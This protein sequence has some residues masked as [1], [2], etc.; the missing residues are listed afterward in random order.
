ML[1]SLWRQLVWK[2]MAQAAARGGRPV[3]RVE[4]LEDRL[5]PAAIYAIPSAS[6]AEASVTVF[7]SATRS[8]KFVL[9]PF[10]GFTGGVNV[11]IG[12]VTGDGTPDVIVAPKAGGGGLVSV[13]NGTDGSLLKSFSVGDDSSR[14]GASVAA[15]DFDA[16]GLAEV[17]VGAVR[18]GQPL[19]QVYR[20]S[21]L[22]VLHGYTPFSGAGGVSVAVGDVTGD[23]TPD[24][25]AAAGPGAGPQVVVFDGKTDA[26]VRSFFAFEPTFTGGVGVAA[27]D[28]DGDGR[29]DILVSAGPTG[30]PRV[31]V[32]SGLTGA[33]L[34]N[35]FA[36]SDQL[37]GGVE[38]TLADT[39][40]NGRLD[41]V[42]T[43]G[44]TPK[45]FDARTMAQ[46]AAPPGGGLVTGGPADTT[47]PTVTLTTT[48]TDPS[49]TSPLKFTATFS[50][51]VNGFS[52]AGVTVVNGTVSNVVRVDAKTYT[53]DVTP[54]ADG[55]VTVTV[56]AG[57]ARDAAGNAS[58]ASAAVSRTFDASGPAVTANALTTN[59]TTPAL[60]GTVDS[61]ATSVTVVVNGQTITATITGTSWSAAVPTALAAGTYTVQVTARD[62]AGNT[63]ATSA[64]LVIDTTAPTATVSTTAPEPTNTS[65]IPFTVTFDEDVT[66]FTAAGLNVTNGVVSNF[67][68]VNARTYTFS[69]APQAQGAVTVTV[70][71]GAAADTAGNTNATST[72]VTRTFDSTGPV[73]TANPLTTNDTTPTLTGTVDNAAATVTV[74][75]GGQTITATVTGTT[76]T[77]TLP[78]ALAAGT[79]DIQVTATD[80]QGNSGTTTATG[81]LVI[82]TTAPTAAVATTATSPTNDTSIT[83]TVT[84]SEDVTGFDQADL[85]VTGGTVASVT[86]VDGKTYT[87]VITP[88]GDGTVSVTVNADAAT[89]TAGNTSTASNTASVVFDG[90]APTPT[91]TADPADPTAANPIL[92]TVTFDED[93]TGFT[94]AGVAVTNGSVI[95]FVATD[96]RTYTFGVVPN[97]PGTVTVSTTAGAATDTAGNASGAATP[98]TRT[99]NGTVVT[100]AITS[101]VTGPTQATTIPVTVEF[102]SDVTGFDES[103]L[104]LTNGTVSNFVAVDGNTYT[105][106]LTPTADGAVTV[107]IAAGAATA[108]GSPTAAATFTIT[109][110]QTAPTA[111]V[112]TGLTSPTNTTPIPFTVTFSEDVTGFDQTG[113]TITGGTLLSFTPVDGKTYTVVVTP[114]GDGLVSVTVNAGVAVDAAG[115]TN[116]AS[117][118]GEITFDGTVPTAAVSTTAT[119]P[120]AANP[121]TFTVTFGE[122]V[123]GFAAG[124]LTVVNGTV[125]AITPVDGKT[126]TVTITPTGSGLVSVTV[127]AGAAADAAGNDNT[128]SNTASVTYDGTAPTATATALTTS[129]TTP[130]LTGTVDDPAATVTVVVGGQTI[131]ATVT[132]TTWTATL[133]NALPP[134][135]YDVQ[136]TATDALGND[137]TTTVTG[138]LVIDTA[139]PTVTISAPSVSTVAGGPVTFT[140]T[141]AD[142]TA[143]TV[144]LAVADVTL[145]PTGNATGT[146]AVTG[147][148]LV[149]TVTI[150]GITGT[151][152]L[153]ISL[154]AGTATDAAGNTAAAAG[155]SAAVTVDNTAPPAPTVTGLAAGS[156]TGTSTAD[157]I[158]SD[159]TPTITGIAEA[160]STVEVFANSGSGPVSL[161]TATANAGGVWSLTPSTP[162]TDATYTVTAVA[163]DAAGND[164]PASAA[165]TLKID[166]AIP[167]G[168]VTTTSTGGVQGGAGDAGGS[169]VARVEVSIF[170]PT[171]NRYWNPQTQSF[172]SQTEVF[173][174]ATDTSAGD[175]FSSW[176]YT[177]PGSVTGGLTVRARVTDLAGNTVTTDPTAVTVS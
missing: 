170:N 110:D 45:A 16:D 147:S 128:A 41:I 39:D 9:S 35:F 56:A 29:A 163:T 119:D 121:I 116:P 144:D 67:V 36:Y 55:L 89:D 134:G 117:A 21:D 97:A 122:D 77:A 155:P 138:G 152:T 175:D 145:V 12:D 32:F 65:P 38:A 88:G 37:R 132:G 33:S 123:T 14:A 54:A 174:D 101:T 120:T 106:D 141:Y 131:T 154:A 5:T 3:L 162:L 112:T 165:Y 172:D 137:A 124:G 11:A 46:L 129:D 83:F 81:G 91:V 169:G 69:V 139:A 47:A 50:E 82:D 15:A 6:G 151:G 94:A 96:A 78:N 176:G 1:V 25:I 43:D 10:P 114:A 136:V 85:T 49:A 4:G 28:T 40:G 62:A 70:V 109:S 149:W 48:A 140:I 98:V 105:F 126:Y 68:A 75:V 63:R 87:V 80:S 61:T 86:P 157:G 20:F 79:Y 113:L 26:V 31:Q 102:T 171:T 168:G 93:V 150:S 34:V 76:W 57:A 72:T 135:T 60:T 22:S 64:T 104:V 66:G 160:G 164:S 177:L 8:P 130:T 156:D 158:T 173:F 118:P 2:R 24:V 13:Y 58:T 7:D 23:G 92:F 52:A 100:A 133:P 30:G 142:A 148:G 17:V 143:V 59:D 108:G 127:N 115:N 166:T 18:N 95:N 19:V 159:A 161:G 51:A 111:A 167:T 125:A 74:V 27:G 153:A 44:T 53:F 103:D 146:V 71:A 42:T 84:F 99:F 90:T 107:S 73:V